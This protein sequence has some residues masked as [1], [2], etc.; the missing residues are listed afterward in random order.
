MGLLIVLG[1]CLVLDV[2]GVTYQ[3]ASS[4]VADADQALRNAFTSVLSAEQRGANVS[5]L[6]FRLDEA[7]DNLTWA[8]LAL[9]AGNFSDAVSFAEVCSSEAVSVG[10]NAVALGNDALVVA[11]EWWVMVVFSVVGSVVFVVVL[12]FVWRG[13]KG[14]YL[15]KVMG[16]RPK[17]KG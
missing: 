3:D 2:H 11:G 9:A 7:G 6:L 8:E 15:K 16:S 14:S 1:V 5:V 17:V 12:I 13:F 4:Q 10:S